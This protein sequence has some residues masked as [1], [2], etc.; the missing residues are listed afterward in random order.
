MV[1]TEDSIVSAIYFDGEEISGRNS[2]YRIF[3]PQS[4]PGTRG[5]NLCPKERIFQLLG[6]QHDKDAGLQKTYKEDCGVETHF[7]VV[8][9]PIRFLLRHSFTGEDSCRKC[10]CRLRRGVKYS[11][12][13]PRYEEVIKL[14]MSYILTEN[15]ID[16]YR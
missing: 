4:P 13:D 1:E 16:F 3:D 11:K 12:D 10:D 5:F 9:S 15:D 6:T 7:I 14:L 8:D 2:D